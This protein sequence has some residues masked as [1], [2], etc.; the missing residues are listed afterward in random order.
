M[1]TTHKLVWETSSTGILAAK[2]EWTI[3]RRPKEVRTQVF[4]F[5][6]RFARRELPWASGE[7]LVTRNNFDEV[8]YFDTKEDAILY[9]ESLFALESA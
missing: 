3:P 8:R 9:V 1:S 7:Y 2:I 6:R 5:V 4:A